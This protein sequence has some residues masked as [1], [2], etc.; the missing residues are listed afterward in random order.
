[1]I[2]DF[3]VHSSW[4]S[5]CETAAE[6]QVKRAL[7]LGM[8]HICITDHN[9][10]DAPLF[11]PDYFSYLLGNKGDDST[12]SAYLADL[13]QLKE[14]YAGQIEVL[15]GIELGMQPHLAERLTDLSERHP[16]D[17]IICSTHSFDGLDG[18]D[19]RHYENTTPVQ[20]L[21]RYFQTELENLRAF[22]CY[23]TVGHM[24]FAIRY[25]PGAAESF[26]YNQ[27]AD[28]LDAILLHIIRHDKALEINTSKYVLKNMTNPN[29]AIIRR[30]AELG[31]KLI[32]FGSDSHVS[33][34]IGEGFCEVGRMVRD[35]GIR[36]Y[37]VYHRHV[38][39]LFPIIT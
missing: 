8:K 22:Q 34:R 16:F 38:P 39:E 31:G 18:K 35:C 1:M 9:D 2:S 24:D 25:A 26:S 17:F 4:S 37:A 13:Q 5:D 29:P 12:I 19:Q 21:T 36:E 7:S 15:A 28:I 20:A 11:P 23:D 27:Y 33:S 6:E 3:H 10:Y 32:T 14:R 30:Y